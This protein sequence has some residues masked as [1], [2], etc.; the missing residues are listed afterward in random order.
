MLRGAVFRSAWS[1]LQS[2]DVDYGAMVWERFEGCREGPTVHCL[3]I[4][5]G[6]VY[7]EFVLFE[8]L[9]DPA[10]HVWQGSGRYD[11]TVRSYIAFRWG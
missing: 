4:H 10:F 6:L 2:H 7:G 3:G 9:V 8:L 11:T 1:W 5:R